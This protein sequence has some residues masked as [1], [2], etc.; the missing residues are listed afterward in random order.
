MQYL[1]EIKDS[2]IAAFQWATKEGVMAEENMR[3]CVFEVG[4][5]AQGFLGS[6]GQQPTLGLSLDAGGDHQQACLA[7]WSMSSG[8]W[9]HIRVLRGGSHA[10]WSSRSGSNSPLRFHN[11]AVLWCE[12]NLC[13]AQ[14]TRYWMSRTIAAVVT[15]NRL[16][17][18]AVLRLPLPHI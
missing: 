1:N 7:L 10:V 12:W 4:R 15:H 2:C 6:K 8:G 5:P 3:G 13:S 14:C 17:S 9:I 18:K 16:E 11:Q